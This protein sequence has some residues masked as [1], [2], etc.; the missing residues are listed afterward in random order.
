MLYSNADSEN[1]FV[2]GTF[3]S[4]VTDIQV[5]RPSMNER[6]PQ[7]ESYGRFDIDRYTF[8]WYCSSDTC[9]GTHEFCERSLNYFCSEILPWQNIK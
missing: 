5:V 8:K 6:M 9:Q 3:R 7:P 1:L 2:L 4:G